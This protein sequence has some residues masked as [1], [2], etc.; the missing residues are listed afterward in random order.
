M[1]AGAPFH[2]Q[3]AAAA[4]VEMTPGG[5]ATI[6]EYNSQDLSPVVEIHAANLFTDY[7]RWGFF[8]IGA[9][10]MLVADHVQVKIQ[11]AA[12]LANALAGLKSWH[13]AASAS[14]GFEMRDLEIRLRG[15]KDA[16]L[17]AVRARVGHDG[18]INLSGVTFRD[19]GGEQISIPKA[20]LQIAG[21]S[22]GRLSWN[23][24]GHPEERYLFQ[25]PND[26]KP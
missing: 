7:E 5:E 16:R 21:S 11:S 3:V 26:K 8:R 20:T 2:T 14:R 6:C 23:R 12:Y 4:P 19:A 22:A 17:R 15:E 13:Q 24:S 18:A 25:T 1:V 10:P 9:L